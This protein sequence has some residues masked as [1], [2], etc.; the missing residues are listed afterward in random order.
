MGKINNQ[1]S[2]FGMIETQFKIE[3]KQKIDEDKSNYVHGKSWLDPTRYFFWTFK[4][5]LE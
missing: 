3:A 5:T 2:E 4:E 1:L